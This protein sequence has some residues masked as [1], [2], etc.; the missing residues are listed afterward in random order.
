MRALSS[1]TRYGNGRLCN[2]LWII[3]LIAQ[4]LC[5]VSSVTSNSRMLYAFARD[6]AVPG[7]KVWHVINEKVQI[8]VNAVWGMC[9]AALLIALPVINNVEA[10]AA[11]TSIATIGL[12]ISYGAPMLCRLT[13][14]R[15]EVSVHSAHRILPPSCADTLPTR[16]RSPCSSRRAR[17]SLAS[18]RCQVRASRAPRYALRPL[19]TLLGARSPSCSLHRRS[20]LGGHHHHLLRAAQ[21]LPQCVSPAPSEIPTASTDLLAGVWALSS[22]DMK[23]NFNYAIIA[24][25]VV[26]V[27]S[28]ATWFLPGPKP[29]N[30]RTWFKG[31]NLSG[32]ATDV[33]PDAGPGA[34]M[35]GGALPPV[36]I[37]V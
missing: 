10:F 2:G 33:V 12:Y 29:L 37:G 18:C 19:L 22:V 28:L 16:A 3:P 26:L 6:N 27:Y 30:A 8:P 14:G 15:K 20:L 24:V 25:G 11:V 13:V 21:H 7:S 1:Q 17:S 32:L 31:P 9:L 36:P 23:L 35:H 34:S 4:F 5:T